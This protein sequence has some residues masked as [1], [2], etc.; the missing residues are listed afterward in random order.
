MFALHSSARVTLAALASLSLAALGSASTYVVDSS[1]GVGSDFTDIPPAIAA[2]QPG[3]VLLVLSGN[4][5]GFTR[6]T[7]T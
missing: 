2:A 3:D 5:S 4:Y 6:R 1:G 7:S